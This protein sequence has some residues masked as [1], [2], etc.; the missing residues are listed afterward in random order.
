M[1]EKRGRVFITGVDGQVGRALVTLADAAGMAVVPCSRRDL[2]LTRP[3]A[4]LD[5]LDAARPD[6]VVN[7]AAYTEVD[8]AE[9]ETRL[10]FAVN[11]EAPAMM[12]R[13]CADN[14]R[15][16]VHLST[17]YVFSGESRRP[18]RED[19]DV[20]PLNVYGASKLAGENAV[21]A[22]CAHH[23]IVRTAW[24][25]SAS[26]RNFVKTMLRLGVERPSLAVVDDQWGCPTSAEN[27]GRFLILVLSRIVDGDAEAIAGTYHY[28]DRGVTTWYDFARRIFEIA[29]DLG[30]RPSPI[31]TPIAS[32]RYP[33]PSRRPLYSVLDTAKFEK[34][35]E[36]VPPE[37]EHSLPG[38]V[39]AILGS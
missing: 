6:L 24:I 27:L 15:G 37:W 23:I 7:C 13:W 28:V 22:T 20:R 21:R 26:G 8:R 32:E 1:S 18:Y 38:V 17:D 35:F 11:A 16:L 12:A 34:V 19:D 29:A 30:G 31:V 5:S 36:H 4:I 14:H 9:S 39:A 10:A 3:S 33:T 25:Y 2:D